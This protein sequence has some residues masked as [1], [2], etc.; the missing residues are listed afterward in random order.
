MLLI[1][2]ENPGNGQGD[3]DKAGDQVDRRKPDPVFRAEE[4]HAQGQV[5]GK[6]FVE[7]AVGRQAG[8]LHH[9]G[10]PAAEILPE[11]GF[12]DPVAEE[13]AQEHGGQDDS[14]QGKNF[15]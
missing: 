5:I 10:E 2:K 9:G 6:E 3:E 8:E 4:G 12:L 14:P 7:T 15:E 11:A 1:F 13:T